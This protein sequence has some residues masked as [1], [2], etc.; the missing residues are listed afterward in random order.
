MVRQ[1]QD[2]LTEMK[3][4]LIRLEQWIAADRL[5]S[6]QDSSIELETLF[7]DMLNL[8]FGWQLGN[9]NAIFGK[10]QDSFDLSDQTASIAIQVTV[11]TNAA[12]IRK[13]LKTFIGKHRNSFN[14]LAFVYPVITLGTSR[15]D[16]TKDAKGFDFDAVRDRLCFGTVLE[17]AQDMKIDDQSRLLEFLRKELRPLG[18]AIQMG[19]DQTVE[20]LISVIQYM[21]DNAPLD[22]VQP[23][24][25]RPD[26]K[27]KLERFRDHA[28]YLLNQ[29]RLNQA[30]HVTVETAREAIGYDTVR[31][32]KIQTWLKIH[33]LEAL[34][35]H[36][37]D[38]T[39]AFK[40]MVADLLQRS[41]SGGSDAEETAVRF[42]LADEFIR[43]NVFPNPAN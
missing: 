7:R 13:T 25:L 32:A 36:G 28:H 8:T 11:T 34:H 38:A 35:S 39:A 29:Y 30:L 15:A 24:E 2:H 22:A 33:S 5:L 18:A 43:C 42:L 10:N 21:S 16:F 26:Q 4:W 12:K 23:N 17:K 31:A 1:R 6:H 9:A 37:N 27:K 19:V 3:E 20:T 14:R 41:H 40:S